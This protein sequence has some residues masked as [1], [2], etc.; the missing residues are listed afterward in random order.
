[1]PRLVQQRSNNLISGA[2]LA[3]LCF[4]SIGC[5]Y[6]PESTF[7]LASD[8]RLPKWISIPSGLKRNSISV[9]MSYYGDPSGRRAIFRVTDANGH[10]LQQIKGVV[11]CN[12][13]FHLRNQS[14]GDAPGH[15]AYE[16]VTVAGVTEI[17][18]HRWK[19]EPRFH[20]TD[21]P[22]IWKQYLAQGCEAGSSP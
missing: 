15:S 22:A 14:E 11:G 8:S 3:I 19:D 9:T 13:P 6:F 18:E 4:T 12:E 16:A 20:V 17:M 10:L 2:L 21:D 1:M 5:E 7:N